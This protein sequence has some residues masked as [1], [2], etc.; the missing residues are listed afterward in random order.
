MKRYYLLFFGISFLLACLFFFFRIPI[1]DGEIIFEAGKQ[2]LVLPNKLSLSYFIGLG[3]HEGEL[4]GVS[5]FRLL[6]IGYLNAFLFLGA[7]PALISY[8]VYIAKKK[9][10]LQQK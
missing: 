7:L 3:F 5:G 8:R 4:N 10:E 2:D 9:K 1:F 6:P